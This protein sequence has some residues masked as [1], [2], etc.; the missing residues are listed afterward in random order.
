MRLKQ[1]SV[2][3]DGMQEKTELNHTSTIATHKLERPGNLDKVESSF[4]RPFNEYSSL[5]YEKALHFVV[6]AA[7]RTMRVNGWDGTGTRVLGR[8]LALE[9]LAKGTCP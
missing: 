2:A 7:G 1:N 8:A 6:F 4:L 5:V 9:S 3:V